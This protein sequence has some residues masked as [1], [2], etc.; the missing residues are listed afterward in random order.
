M[1]VDTHANPDAQRDNLAL[2]VSVYAADNIP[3][4][5][6]KTDFS[7]MELFIDLKFAESSDPLRDPKDPQQ[8]QVGSFC[9]ENDSGVSQLNCGQL[10]S[11]AVAHAGSQFRVH[12]FTLFICRR[13][14]RCI[15]WDRAGATVTQSFDYI[16][17][18]HI[19]AH[20]LWRYAHLNHSQREYETP[21]AGGSPTDPACRRTSAK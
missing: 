16:K 21:V 13:S 10:C 2:D 14:A 19:L 20:F 3:D 9:F 11:Y 1:L 7:K 12:T 15:R 18:P 4:T 8:P 6:T 5:D 17:E